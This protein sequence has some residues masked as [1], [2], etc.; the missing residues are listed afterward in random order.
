MYI[1]FSPSSAF[2]FNFPDPVSWTLMSWV[3]FN[4][5]FVTSSKLYYNHYP[6]LNIQLTGDMNFQWSDSLCKLLIINGIEFYISLT[7]NL[8]TNIFMMLLEIIICNISNSCK[9]WCN[10]KDCVA[11]KLDLD[12]SSRLNINLQIHRVYFANNMQ[13][14]LWTTGLIFNSTIWI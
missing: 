5:T 11:L 13:D 7:V 12:A 1:F 9:V 6:V 10:K 2:C 14:F 3:K 4:W 8:A